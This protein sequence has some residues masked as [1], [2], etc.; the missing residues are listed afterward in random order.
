LGGKRKKGQSLQGIGWKTFPGKK[1]GGPGRGRKLENTLVEIKSLFSIVRA[2]A[3]SE[4]KKSLQRLISGKRERSVGI[5]SISKERR[6]EG[7]GCVHTHKSWKE[8]WLAS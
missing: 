2:I 5:E 8:R 4:N 3:T 1:R 7:K 6:L